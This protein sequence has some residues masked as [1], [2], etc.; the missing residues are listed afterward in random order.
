M[1]RR[2]MRRCAASG[3]ISEPKLGQRLECN[4]RQRNYARLPQ[5]GR[6]LRPSKSLYFCM[7]F[8]CLLKIEHSVPKGNDAM[9]CQVAESA[10]RN[11]YAALSIKGVGLFFEPALSPL[12]IP[13]PGNDLRLRL[14]NLKLRIFIRN[15]I[16]VIWQN[17]AK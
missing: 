13:A 14:K 7:G 5:P 2:A 1:T 16:I 3:R 9:R 4:E 11:C 6:W 15:K 8:F 12:I 17:N 10:S